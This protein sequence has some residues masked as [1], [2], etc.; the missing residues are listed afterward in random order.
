MKCFFSLA[1]DYVH[2]GRTVWALS[3][4]VDIIVAGIAFLWK[5]NYENLIAFC[6]FVFFLWLFILCLHTSN[7]L[8]AT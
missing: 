3:M 5:H 1:S 2:P 6:T 7:T 4:R 8:V